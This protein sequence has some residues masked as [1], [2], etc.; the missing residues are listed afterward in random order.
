MRS[1]G[2]AI[3]L[4]VTTLLSIT[5]LFVTA[6]PAEAKG[7]GYI[8]CRPPTFSLP[9]DTLSTLGTGC[10]TARRVISGFFAKAQ[11]RGPRIH[12]RGFWCVDIPGREPA[13]HCRR[14]E[15]RIL[16]RGPQG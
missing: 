10:K 12:V 6:H 7:S 15:A 16:Y 4:C 14:G 11:T 9:S 8:T 5:T 13:I 2:Q 3:L 1:K